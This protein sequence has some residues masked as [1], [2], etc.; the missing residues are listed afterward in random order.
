MSKY[1]SINTLLIILLSNLLNRFV[2]QDRVT[3]NIL[4]FRVV[5]RSC[6]RSNQSMSELIDVF[7]TEFVLWLCV[8]IILLVLY[9]QKDHCTQPNKFCVR[10]VMLLHTV[11]F[12]IS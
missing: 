7:N 8:I 10:N 3:V 6:T 4:C 9:Q 2:F 12:F 1:E 5:K 11:T